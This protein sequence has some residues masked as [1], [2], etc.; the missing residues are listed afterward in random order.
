MNVWL[1]VTVAVATSLGLAWVN[2]RAVRKE[3]AGTDK[4]R[5][6]ALA[7]QE[8]A[9]AF[10]HLQYRKLAPVVLL[11]LLVLGALVSWEAAVAFAIG[12]CMSATAGWIGM[13]TATLA[14]VRVANKARET[15]NLG[16]T[17]KL[18]FIGGS[19][20]GLCV[21]GFALL[22]LGLVVYVFG[23]LLGQMR[24]EMMS[25]RDNWLGIPDIRD[26]P[27]TMTVSGYALGC[28]IIAMFN[29]VGGGIY[30]KAADMGADLVG[31]MEAG[32][33]EDDPRNP[34]T[35][36]DNV[37]DN[38]GDVAGLGSDLLE[39]YVGALISALVLVSC[40]FFSRAASDSPMTELQLKKLIAFPLLFGAL[41]L[42]ACVAGIVVMLVRKISD[43]PHRELNGVTTFSALLTILCTGIVDWRFFAGEDMAAMGFRIGWPSPWACAVLGILAG[44]AI[45]KIAE[46]YT[47]I[48]YRPTKEV[49]EASHEGAALTITQ[50]MACGMNSVMGPVLVL[51]TTII[52]AHTFGGLYGVA[53]AAIG[54][55]S[56]V[57]VTVAVDTYGP[58]ADN[59]GGISEMAQLN[60]RVREIT[61]NL[62]AVG[63]TTAAIGKGFAIGSA[64]LAALSLFAS[65]V[66]ALA[67]ENAVAPDFSLILN[68][69]NTLTLS[70]A[71]IGAALPY[72][73]SGI[74]IEAVAR[75]ARRMVQEVREQFEH[76]PGIM[77]GEVLPNYRQCVEISSA[78][79][80]R[81]MKIPAL[82]AVA[83]PLFF[84][85]IFGADFVGGLLIG[86][87][88]SAVMLALYTANAGGAWDNGKKYIEGG[89]YGGK[90]SEAH[91]AAVVGDTVGDP[92]KDTVGPSLDILIKIMS[93]VSLIFVSIFSK[94]NIYDWLTSFMR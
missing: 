82:I 91:K 43:H 21:G 49:A 17:L 55:L 36:A 40:I 81:E 9:D 19:V 25:L 74:L 53:M 84:G 28:S 59:A 3:E 32:I 23:H 12:A 18:A 35:I 39:S 58:I 63:N 70:G 38:V 87:T 88:L 22:G 71:V 57:T 1:L 33:P 65:Y 47:S 86:T 44:I 56:F 46:Y 10:L 48:D 76:N 93:V 78:G 85:F 89:H 80:L 67:G 42:L 72:L 37:G 64:A 52:L 8:G 7:I 27:F 41:G 16:Q 20:M 51:G 66:Y 15:E 6:I 29:R 30:T 60:H 54:M 69:I 61:D 5:A 73:F 13:K 50:G 79:A 24:P 11:I 62:D 90:G 45:G 4:M 34:A 2:F 75:A 14:N 83:S 94:Y 68:M 77:T 26:I 92:L 31:K